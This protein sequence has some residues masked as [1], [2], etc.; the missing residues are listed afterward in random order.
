MFYLF[1]G[2]QQKKR[3]GWTYHWMYHWM[4]ASDAISQ[5]PRSIQGPPKSAKALEASEVAPFKSLNK[6]MDWPIFEAKGL[7]NF[8]GKVAN[9]RR[10]QTWTSRTTLMKCYVVFGFFLKL[11]YFQEC[12]FWPRN[13]CFEIYHHQSDPI[14]E[15]QKPGA[16]QV[17]K[18][19]GTGA[20]L[21]WLLHICDIEGSWYINMTFDRC[22]TG[23]P[24]N[25]MLWKV[26]FLLDAFLVPWASGF[27]HVSLSKTPIS[28]Q[29]WTGKRTAKPI[30]NTT[31][32]PCQKPVGLM[33]SSV[34]LRGH[35]NIIGTQKH[36]RHISTYNPY[37]WGYRLAD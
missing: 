4:D 10:D 14:T 35:F 13:L 1:L 28:D 19:W 36:H 17:R 32:L 27:L 24:E 5:L 31:H 33:W 22:L 21:T 3:L 37:E 8:V 20:R 6:A 29:V 34:I 15:V 18:R 2:P 16:G 11:T 7:M 30:L 12:N 23:A 26:T 25:W 9:K